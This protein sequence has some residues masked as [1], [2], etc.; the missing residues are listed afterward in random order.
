MR[1]FDKEIYQQRREGL[2]KA[3]GKGIL[4]I[5]G[6]GEAA[7]NYQGNPYHFRQNSNFL[8]YFG[9]AQPDLHAII[10]LDNDTTTIYGNELTM[11][12]IIWMG[13]VASLSSLASNVGVDVVKSPDALI[14]DLKAYPKKSIHFLPPYR[15]EH[16]TLLFDALGIKHADQA[17]KASLKLIKAV[18]AQRSIKSSEEIE[19]MEKAVNITKSMHVR[20]MQRTKEEKYEYEVVGD[21]LKQCKNY[22][23]SLAYGVIFSINGQVLHNHHHDNLMVSGR[24]VLNDS[25]AENDMYYAGDITRTFPVNGKFTQKQKEIYEIVLEMEKSCIEFIGPGVKYY[26]AH[27]HANSILIERF[28]ALGLLKGETSEMLDAGVAGLFMPH[29]L[30]HMIGLDVHD[31]EDLGEQYV[32]YEDGQE[33]A[34]MLGLKSLRLARTLQP[35]FTLTVEPGIYFIPQLIEKYKSE[36]KFMDY[37][38]YDKLKEYYDFGGIRIEDNVLITEDG[39][40]V[41]GEPIP[42]EIWEVEK[43]MKRREA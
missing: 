6:N 7:M 18:I 26:D 20:A 28:K 24:L 41:L 12:D 35:G 40:R 2:K 37:V 15:I 23:G 31:M 22:H 29:G 25:G 21:I 38:N 1:L 39:R 36:G 42:K 5:M 33:R 34:T 8:Y 9:I 14:E 13:E 27:L 4:L 16:Q 43:I 11:D 32:G 30:G 19:E 3:M 17:A 10:D